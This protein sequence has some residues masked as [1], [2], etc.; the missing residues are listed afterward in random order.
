M[1]GPYRK[2][3]TRKSPTM[4]DMEALLNIYYEPKLEGQRVIWKKWGI[5]EEG[6]CECGWE[7]DATISW[8]FA[9]PLLTIKCRKEDFI[10]TEKM[11]YKVIQIGDNWEGNLRKRIWRPAL[12]KKEE[13]N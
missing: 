12:P 4:V 8:L 13:E 9:C 11:S 6:K 10:T 2:L 5:K 1:E 7:Q 3:T